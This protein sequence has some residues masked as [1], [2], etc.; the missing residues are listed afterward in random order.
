M[1]LID[2]IKKEANK[3]FTKTQSTQ[4]VEIEGILN[5][6]HYLDKNI[7]KELVFLKSVMTRGQESTERKG[8]HASAIIVS[9]K[10]FCLRQQVL[11][12][13]Y[14]QKQGEQVP[15][16]LKRI[17]SEGDAIHEKWQRLF[18]RGGLCEPLD[19]DYSRFYDEYDLSYTPDIIC[20][21]NG[22]QYVVE[23]KSVNT[24]QFKNMIDKGNHHKTGRRQLQLYMHFTGIH[25]G[26]VLCED[27]NT[28]EIKVFC[29]EYNFDE[30]EKYVKRLEDIQNAKYKLINKHKLVKRSKECTSYHCELAEK[31]AMREVCYGRKKE[32]LK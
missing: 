16:G 24:Y 8:L 26:F 15:I 3:T 28:Q 10:K 7:N 27:K 20:R 9:D 21:I 32:R 1:G 6:L 18:I 12:I 25:N 17:F 2:S 23:I 11:S 30:I 13:F 14:K 5:S 4:E 19:C 29:Y 22:V 31:C